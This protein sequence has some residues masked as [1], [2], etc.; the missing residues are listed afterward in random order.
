MISKSIDKLPHFVKSRPHFGNYQIQQK[1][2]SNWLNH[3]NDSA[4]APIIESCSDLKYEFFLNLSF[5][6][7]L[8]ATIDWSI[9]KLFE[10]FT[11][12]FL[13]FFFGTLNFAP[14][15]EPFFLRCALILV[16][17]WDETS[18]WYDED[19]KKW[20]WH[21]QMCVDCERTWNVI[22]LVF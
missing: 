12:R 16:Y 11:F 7:K 3:A 22:S 6:R 4:L 9:S 20:E 13:F 14:D 5:T 17:I 2:H 1:I 19:G 21:F 18:K 15:T 8:S 10:S